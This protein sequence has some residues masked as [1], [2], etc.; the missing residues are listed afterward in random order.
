MNVRFGTDGVRGAVGSELSC[1]TVMNI[2]RAAA[3]VCSENGT[4]PAKIL[5]GKDTRASSDVLEAALCAGICSGGCDAHILGVIPTQGVSSLVQSYG[6]SAGF[7]ITASHSGAAYNGVKLFGSSG[8]RMTGSGEKK[9]EALVDRAK[10]EPCRR[11]GRIMYEEKAEWDYIRALIK[12]AGCD[13]RGLKVAL[14]CANGSA[15]RYAKRVFEGLGAMTVVV[16][17]KPDGENINRLCGSADTSLLCETVV[18]KRCD[19]GL[20][21]DGDCSKCI[22]VDE[23]GNVIDGDKLLA[24]FSK[25]LKVQGRLK[26]NTCVATVMSN[27]GLSDFAEHEG[28]TLSFAAVGSGAVLERMM[29]FGYNL[30]GERNGHIVFLDDEKTGDGMLTGIRLLEIIKKSRRRASTLGGIITPY[31]QIEVNVDIPQGKRGIWAEDEELRALVSDCKKKLG[32]DGRII[33]RESGTEALVRV[34]AEGKRTGLIIDYSQQIA[35]KIAEVLNRKTPAELEKERVL[36][37]LMEEVE[38]PLTV[39]PELRTDEEFM[40]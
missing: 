21:F 37:E 30:G 1:E 26:H 24:I 36:R 34:M 14:D 11:F 28:I 4:K 27:L 12:T 3:V 20:A 33:V 8:Y 22:A 23:L 15:S 5:I 9:I 40:I 29:Q 13:L 6:A 32:E 35:K 39:L 7:M 19:A 25:F 16:S 31:P 38:D 10:W 17:D 18:K 2:G